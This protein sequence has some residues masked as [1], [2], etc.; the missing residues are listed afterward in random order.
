MQE[1]NAKRNT[2]H[3]TQPRN[4][5]KPAQEDR[6]EVAFRKHRD[7]TGG[8]LL[9]L[10]IVFAVITLAITVQ[11]NELK[12]EAEAVSANCAVYATGLEK[13]QAR[14]EELDEFE[15]YTHTKKYIEEQAK[16]LGYVYDGEIIYRAEQ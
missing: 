16:S 15:V 5:R 2:K 3:Q 10:T 14:S 12:T 7:S 9:I 11:Y 13:E 1:S 6:R 8:V 4:G